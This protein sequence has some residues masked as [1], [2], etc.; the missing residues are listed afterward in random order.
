MSPVHT[1]RKA[2]GEGKK[3][4]T[5]TLSGAFLGA[6]LPENGS[7]RLHR[8]REQ[9]RARHA[10]R[11]PTPEQVRF[12]RRESVVTAFDRVIQYLGDSSMALTGEAAM[13]FA[14][15]PILDVKMHD[16][17]FRLFPALDWVVA[18]ENEV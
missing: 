4:G 10:A 2:G 16:A 9:L 17:G 11:R 15:D 6:D 1:P 12:Q 14:L 7:Q 8:L 3:C 5:A 18:A 13:L